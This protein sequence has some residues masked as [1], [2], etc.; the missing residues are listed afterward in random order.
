MS[1][2]YETILPEKINKVADKY[3]LVYEWNIIARL[4]NTIR[5]QF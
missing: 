4:V 5:I 2:H 3:G 1:H